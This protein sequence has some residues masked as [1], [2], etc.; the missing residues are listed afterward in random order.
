MNS[1]PPQNQ[2]SDNFDG[3]FIQDLPTENNV[4]YADLLRSSGTFKNTKNVLSNQNLTG[5]A[6][7]TEHHRKLSESPPRSIHFHQTPANSNGMINQNSGYP[8]GRPVN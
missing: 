7:Q 4:S 8:N 1:N 6:T 5:I 3:N 2:A